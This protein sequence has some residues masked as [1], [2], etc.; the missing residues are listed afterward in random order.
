MI[1]MKSNSRKRNHHCCKQYNRYTIRN[2]N[3]CNIISILRQ[4][5]CVAMSL[6]GSEATEAL[7]RSAGGGEGTLE[8]ATGFALATTFRVGLP[9]YLRSL[10]MTKRGLCH[11][12]KAGGLP[13]V[14]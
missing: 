13:I 3:I 1:R 12:L 7:S 4:R 11:S 6:R 10:A 9:R 2:H 14:N 8:I 5:G